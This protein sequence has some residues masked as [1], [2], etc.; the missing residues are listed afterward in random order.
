MAAPTKIRP[1]RSLALLFLVL[2]GLTVWAFWPGTVHTPRL[3]LDLEGGTQVTLVPKSAVN[4]GTVNDDQL[5]QAVEIIRQRVNGLGVA[6][7]EVT[8]QGS[9]A[10]AAIVVSV[11]G[12]NDQSI[13]D[14]ISQTAQLNFR[15]VY[16][17][18]AGTP[19]TTSADS[20]TK[21]TPTP[22]PKKGSSVGTATTPSPTPTSAALVPPIQSAENDAKLQAAYLALDCSKPEATKGGGQPDDP[23]KWIVTCSQDGSAKYLLEPAFIKGTE[24]TEAQAQLP[25][26]GAGGWQV[27]LS[28]N[29][30]GANQLAEVSTKIYQKQSPQNQF[31]IVLDGLVQSSPYFSEPITGGNA[32][33][34]GT[35][36]QEQAKSLAN[37]LK[38]GALPVTLNVAEITTVSPTLGTDQLKAGLIAG[39]LGLLLVVLYLL[40]YYRAL[41]VVAVLSLVVA[42]WFTYVVFVLLGRTVGLALTLAGVAGAIVAI[43]ITAD[44]FVVYFERIRDEV[45]DGRSLRVAAEV[46]WTRA[47]S[48][49]LAADFVSLLAAVILYYLSVGNVRGF[50]FV[51]GLTTIIDIIVAFFFTRPLVA[52]LAGTKWF[53]R[54]GALTGVSP[55]RL[56]IA[57]P[58]EVSDTDADRAADAADAELVALEDAKAQEKAAAR[59]RREGG[60]V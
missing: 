20:G 35:F 24:I 21:A 52:I 7:S 33:I 18:D 46:G 12:S 47:K 10:N 38:Y 49:I 30:T 2:A 36:T 50:A 19:S 37:V 53:N 34:T 48:T 55:E 42:A 45:R 31:A 5:K 17:E 57:V 58:T 56:G 43:G 40:A 15:P 29:Q 16:A 25:T 59:A 28:F 44:S 54:G 23:A 4:G 51:L 27:T 26:Q 9:G 13:R 8:I 11:P 1:W 14:Q 22:T 6:E 41:G 60:E 32:Q 3:G 39:G